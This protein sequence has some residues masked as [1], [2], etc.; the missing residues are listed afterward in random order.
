MEGSVFAVFSPFSKRSQRGKEF[1]PNHRLS[2]SLLERLCLPSHQFNIPP[3]PPPSKLSTPTSSGMLRGFVVLRGPG[4]VCLMRFDNFKM[5][6]CS[7][8]GKGTQHESQISITFKEMKSQTFCFN[9]WI[10]G[11][12]IISFFTSP[13]FMFAYLFHSIAVGML[14]PRP[15]LSFLHCSN[16]NKSNSCSK[17]ISSNSSMIHLLA[18]AV[19]YSA[20]RNSTQWHGNPTASGGVIAERRNGT[21]V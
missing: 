20:Q 11:W 19:V 2:T 6:M 1:N 14:W 3:P 5:C 13:V 18:V 10:N 15:L 4:C 21:Q 17:F 7:P 8:L 9:I 12:A 16:V